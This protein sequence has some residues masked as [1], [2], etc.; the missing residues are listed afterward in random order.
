M[1][2]IKKAKV[3]FFDK[4]LISQFIQQIVAPS[5]SILFFLGLF[6]KIPFW[7]G[8]LFAIF[9]ILA[10][11]A[12]WCWANR[13][14][15]RKIYI[16][17]TLLE[18]KIGDIFNESGLK[19]IAFNEYFDTKVDELII[20]STSLNGK[21]IKNKV[22]NI[23]KLDKFIK[24]DRCLQER[25]AQ[26]NQARKE[27]KKVKYKLGSVFLYENEYILTAFSRFD[28][29]NKAYLFMPDY[30]EFL[31]NFWND[32]DRVYAGRSVVI[33][34]LG[35]GITRFRDCLSINEQELLEI[36]IWSLKI[37]QVRFKLPAQ[38]KIV[39][40]PDKK[41]NINFYFLR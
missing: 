36:M 5:S 6:C 31:V 25:V 23:N 27:G 29:Q 9:L 20:A 37:S 1:N 30:L 24:N 3:L 39:I 15:C 26:E 11:F 38:I 13:L 35:S 17:G 34:L 28:D 22:K 33:P 7:L 21:F 19:V 12:M 10:Y 16:N 14:S 18:V 40:N 8:V 4:T 2:N 41:G 32:I